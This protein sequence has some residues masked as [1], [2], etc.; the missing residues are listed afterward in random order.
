MY[1]TILVHLDD[2]GSAPSVLNIAIDLAQQNSA[3]L[4]GLFVIPQIN[5]PP[6]IIPPEMPI[7]LLKR[8]NE[9]Y[10][11]QSKDLQKYFEETVHKSSVSWEWNNIQ[12]KT[13]YIGR[14]IVERGR[15]VDL[16][17]MSQGDMD[18]I[19]TGKSELPGYV[20]METGR[21]VIVVPRKGDFKKVGAYPLVAWNASKEA[22]RATF[23]AM[24]VL[25]KANSVKVMWIDPEGFSGKDI[26]IAGSSIAASIARTGVTVEAAQAQSNELDIGEALSV[27]VA[28]SGADL[29]VMGAYG[30]SRLREYMFGGATQYLLNNMTV[31]VFISH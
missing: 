30:H 6:T 26:N 2:M 23:D 1:N 18:S 4:V 28:G 11:K 22:A 17:I 31:P 12:S 29:I 20:I 27:Q 13:S 9:K 15:C 5:I 7:E 3:H 10:E 25:E 21:P 24:P 14:D 16:V 19:D 8:H